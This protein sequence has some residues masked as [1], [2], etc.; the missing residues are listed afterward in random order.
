MPGCSDPA[1]P[2]VKFQVA[3]GPP[4]SQSCSGQR[5]LQAD[6]DQQAGEGLK[7]FLPSPSL[8][9]PPNKG[10][11]GFLPDHI[12]AGASPGIKLLGASHNTVRP[13]LPPISI[14]VR[15]RRTSPES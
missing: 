12:A 5:R 1:Q 8:L 7:G 4:G 2:A 14:S 15:R 10:R 3:L 13:A 9:S 11:G 6:L